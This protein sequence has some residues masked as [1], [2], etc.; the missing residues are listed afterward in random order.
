MTWKAFDSKQALVRL[1]AADAKLR[2]TIERVGDYKLQPTDMHSPFEALAESIVYQQI[3]GKAAATIMSRLIESFAPARFPSPGQL[4]AATEDHLRLAGISRPKV[5]ALKDL[6]AS[7][8][9][10]TVPTL[11][12]LEA[13]ADDE[14]VDRLVS[15]RG[16]GRWTVE[17]LLIFRLGRQDVLPIHDY[18]L[19]K[20]FAVTFGT[21]Q[22]PTPEEIRR[23]GERW[24]PYRTVASWYLW[25]ASEF[26]KISGPVKTGTKKG[27]RA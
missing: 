13:M 20:G 15:V 23:R 12:M 4:L 11:E 27:G 7:T 17:M 14:I 8:I 5:A 21:G 2:K 26:D 6:A 19:R 24:R 9:D 10:G 18:G 25:R 3:T 16:I 1:C 22:L